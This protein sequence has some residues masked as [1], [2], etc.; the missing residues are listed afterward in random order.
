MTQLLD[1]YMEVNKRTNDGHCSMEAETY[2]QFVQHIAHCF[3]V[4]V[5]EE[6]TWTGHHMESYLMVRSESQDFVAMKEFLFQGLLHRG[7]N[8]TVV[9]AHVNGKALEEDVVTELIE[10]KPVKQEK[11][12][13]TLLGFVKHIL[14]GTSAIGDVVPD[15]YDEELWEDEEDE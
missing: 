13:K 14:S 2:L 15:E 8:V 10:M 11:K 3:P 5:N 4:E 9:R 7:Y 12:K 1:F 6:T